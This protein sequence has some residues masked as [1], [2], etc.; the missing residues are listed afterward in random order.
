[1]KTI[2]KRISLS[3]NETSQFLRATIRVTRRVNFLSKNKQTLAAH[4][5]INGGFPDIGTISKVTG[6]H[7]I[8][9]LF[10]IGCKPTS[11]RGSKVDS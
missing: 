5:L 1:M 7:L 8:I 10:V 2:D 6:T 3:L 11:P 9:V 4:K